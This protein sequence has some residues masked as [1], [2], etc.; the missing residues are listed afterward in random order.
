MNYSR[1]ILGLQSLS[2]K[3]VSTLR[4]IA[5][6]LHVCTQALVYHCVTTGGTTYVTDAIHFTHQS[7]FSLHVEIYLSI[8]EIILDELHEP[9]QHQTLMMS[10]GL[11]PPI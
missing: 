5:K 1:L 4:S 9:Q 10:L 8:I 3:T 7:Q 6:E 11:R 2:N